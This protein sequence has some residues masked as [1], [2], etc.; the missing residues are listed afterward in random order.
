MQKMLSS[1]HIPYNNKMQTFFILF[2]IILFMSF[3]WIS[4]LTYWFWWTRPPVIQSHEGIN[5]IEF[6]IND[7]NEGDTVTVRVYLTTDIWRRKLW[8]NDTLS[9]NDILMHAQYYNTWWA[10][11]YKYSQEISRAPK[12]I[13]SLKREWKEEIVKTITPSKFLPNIPFKIS[14]NKE[15]IIPFISEIPIPWEKIYISFSSLSHTPIA[16]DNQWFLHPEFQVYGKIINNT[17]IL[18]PEDLKNLLPWKMK[19]SLSN[20]IKQEDGTYVIES[21]MIIELVK[22]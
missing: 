13:L 2:L 8:T 14:Q 10:S 15:N 3:F 9:I 21:D 5:D 16:K 7:T 1:I 11:G 17:I 12:Y 18:T 19:T 4:L 22:E 20:I 6:T